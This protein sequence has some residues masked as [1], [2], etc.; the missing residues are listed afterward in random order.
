MPEPNS[1]LTEEQSKTE[2][3]QLL[4]EIEF[5]RDE[6][7][8]F[9]PNLRTNLSEN[10]SRRLNLKEEIYNHFLSL[11]NERKYSRSQILLDIKKE[12][13]TLGEKLEIYEKLEKTF[14]SGGGASK[15]LIL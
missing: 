4:I 6:L 12:I 14:R 10:M 13:E 9:H 2:R 8:K 11:V 15:S 5:L 1:P 3:A 7:N